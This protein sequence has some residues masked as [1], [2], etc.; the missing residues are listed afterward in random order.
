MGDIIIGSQK[1][2]TCSTCRVID[3]HSRFWFYYLYNRLILS[4]LSNFL[5][6]LQNFIPNFIPNPVCLS[7]S[8]ISLLCK[9]LKVT[10][11]N[12]SNSNFTGGKPASLINLLIL[13]R[14]YGSQRF[15]LANS[16]VSIPI[17]FCFNPCF[18]GSWSESHCGIHAMAM[19]FH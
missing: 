16:S 15:K 7:C 3:C 17:T 2:A 4:V 12:V 19:I 5:P 9:R 13:E 6:F 8:I 14:R 11:K 18:N 10:V 1:K